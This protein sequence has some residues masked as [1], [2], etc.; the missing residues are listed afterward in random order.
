M[1]TAL[2]TGGSRGIGL[3]IV[4]ELGLHGYRVAL[5]ATRPEE[6]YPESTE[7]LRKAG[8]DYFWF[9]GDIS[10]SEDRKRV[11]LQAL[12]ALGT[13]DVLV[14]NAGVAPKVR[15]DL[16]TMTEESFD[17]VI[18]TNTK[19]NMFMT[20]AVALQM[21]KQPLHGDKRGTIINISSCSA[22]VSSV[23][24]GEYC[25]SKAGISMLTKL[26]ADRLAPEGIF[27]YEIRPGVIRTDMTSQVEEKYT[28]LIKQGMFP[29][30]RWGVP[31]DV[32]KAVRAFCSDDFCYTTGNYIDVDGGFHIRRL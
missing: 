9:S 13:F 12:E 27:V 17:Y 6:E 2:V 24:R 1:R 5:M 20:Q 28:E 8:V 22:E 30:A 23:N 7:I 18:G 32:A 10:N 3:S 19:A 21:M 11:V 4:K 25:V 14:N 29:I 15:A 26:Y 31:E 16:L